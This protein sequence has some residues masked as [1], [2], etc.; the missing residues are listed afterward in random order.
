M[1]FLG[2]YKQAYKIF[3]VIQCYLS[4]QRF[5]RAVDIQS[6]S[7][8]DLQQNLMIKCVY[9]YAVTHIKMYRLVSK[10]LVLYISPNAIAATEPK[11]G[12][13]VVCSQ[14]IFAV[15]PVRWRR[16]AHRS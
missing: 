1:K 7:L 10:S 15:L 2:L 14:C 6:S 13:I 4:P 12:I 9:L 8:L 16:G 5:I 11:R 3:L